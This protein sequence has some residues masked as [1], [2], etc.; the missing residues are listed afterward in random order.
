MARN[1][2]RKKKRKARPAVAVLIVLLVIIVLGGGGFMIGKAQF[3]SS[4]KPIEP[5]NKTGIT[6]TI[7]QGADTGSIANILKDNGLIKSVNYFKL[8]SRLAGYDGQYKHGQY[9]LSRSMSA[10]QIINVIISG[11]DTSDVVKFTIPEGY[12]TAQIRKVLINKGLVTKDEF[13]AE[14]KSGSFDYKFLDGINPGLHQLDGFLYPD[15]Y[16]VYANAGA[17]DIIVKMLDR[18]NDLFKTEYY[19]R[20]SEMG[21]SVREIVTMASLVEREAVVAS[22]RPTIAGVFYNRIDIGMKLESCATIQYILGHQKEFL[23]NDD[24]AIDSPYNTYMYPGLP[25]GPICSPRIESIEA[26]LY[27]E[28]SDYLYFVVSEKLNGSHNFSADYSKF[29]RDKAAYQ[30]AVA[31]AG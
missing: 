14:L 17:H 28:K 8:H 18:F 10:D 9:K 22:E 2:T 24:L 16:E 7:P 20:A 12:T 25:P 3:N 6:V 19:S 27:P 30:Q 4:L 29:L 1:T 15:T 26:A 13:D 5:G 11:A 23:T 21:Y 31:N